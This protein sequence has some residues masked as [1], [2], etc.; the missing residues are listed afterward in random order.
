MD[1][2]FVYQEILFNLLDN[3]SILWTFLQSNIIA[4]LDD[5]INSLSGNADAILARAVFSFFKGLASL[6]GYQN[7]TVLGFILSMIGPLFAVYFVAVVVRWFKDI[8]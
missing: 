7:L 2:L 3:L 8:I 6:L 5:S 1:G 4:F